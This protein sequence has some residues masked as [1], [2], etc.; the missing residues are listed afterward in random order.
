MS[1]VQHHNVYDG[2]YKQSIRVE[3]QWTNSTPAAI[4]S[5]TIH[6]NAAFTGGSYVLWGIK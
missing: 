5:I 2:S 3:G 4:T 6:A 1:M